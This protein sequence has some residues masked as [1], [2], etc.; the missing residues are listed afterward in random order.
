MCFPFP[1]KIIRI[2]LRMNMFQKRPY[3]LSARIGT[4]EFIQ[5]FSHDIFKEAE[6][7]GKKSVLKWFCFKRVRPKCKALNNVLTK[8]CQNT[9]WI[10]KCLWVKNYWAKHYTS[11]FILC[12][13]I[14]CS[15]IATFWCIFQKVFQL[16]LPGGFRDSN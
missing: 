3:C 12:I 11:S 4:R 14:L 15:T 2:L 13:S 6:E 1:Y 7:K 16:N 9:S 5:N 8:K 10:Q